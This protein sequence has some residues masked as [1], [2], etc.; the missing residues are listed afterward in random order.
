ML[1]PKIQFLR[2]VRF[3]ATPKPT[4]E[5]RALPR[6]CE[7]TTGI[8]D[9]QQ[10][11]VFEKVAQFFQIFGAQRAVDDAVVAAHRERHAMAHSRSDL[12]C[13]A[14]MTGVSSPSSIATAM[15]RSISAY[16]TIASPS[17]EA[18]TRGTLTAA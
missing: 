6:V 8:L 4:R 9:Q 18:F 7:P 11:R 14:R 16:C 15:P 1:A 3:G 13:A 5:S 2:K 17:K 12:F 10:R